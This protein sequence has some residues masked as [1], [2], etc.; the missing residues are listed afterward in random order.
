MLSETDIVNGYM[1]I[2]G[3]I[4]DTSEIAANFACYQASTENS[5]KDFQY[6]LLVS[7]EFRNRRLWV[8]RLRRT[9]RPGLDRQRL[10]F[11]H[12]EKCG[13]TTLHAMLSSQFPPDRI[14]PERFGTIGDWTINELADYDLF[15]GH[16]DLPSCRSI[17]GELRVITMLREP[18]SRLLSLFSFWKAH[19]PDP[20]RDLYDLI[21]IARDC[22]AEEF[23]AHDRV[24]HHPNV[25]DAMTGQLT[26]TR[27]VCELEADN[28][29]LAD[30]DQALADATAALESLTSFGLVEAYEQSRV[31]L[32]QTLGLHMEQVAPCQVLDVLMRE[33]TDLMPVPPVTM[34]PRLD[35]L[36][37]ALTPIDRRLYARARGIFDGRMA[38]LDTVSGPAANVV[39]GTARLRSL[40][41][42]IGQTYRLP[43]GAP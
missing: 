41:S 43:T 9:T 12:I 7:E 35:R 15:S 16:F 23:F 28:P 42:R 38:A 17:P 6:R 29:I 31:L 14:C 36:L 27:A 10:V 5:L 1:W 11:V 34:S 24:R 21:R 13:G 4:P 22:T 18:K 8:D 25:R 37:D 20:D 3:R 39:Q 26:R 30:P 32:N 33:G 2:L 40:V 19:R